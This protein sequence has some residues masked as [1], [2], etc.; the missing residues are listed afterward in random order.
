M[1]REKFGIYFLD[2]DAGNW[3]KNYFGSRPHISQ[4]VCID[5]GYSQV[6]I[7]GLLCYDIF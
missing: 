3:K 7:F 6:V 5:I 2:S 4:R 1:L